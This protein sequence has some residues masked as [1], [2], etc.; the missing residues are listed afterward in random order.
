M[1]T[2]GKSTKHSLGS[3]L[4]LSWRH[5][6]TV[7]PAYWAVEQFEHPCWAPHRQQVIDTV[8]AAVL[9]Q[10][11]ELHFG[12]ARGKL[13]GDPA[14]RPFH[15]LIGAHVGIKNDEHRSPLPCDSAQIGNRTLHIDAFAFRPIGFPNLA[16]PIPNAANGHRDESRPIGFVAREPS[17]R[18]SL[19][20]ALN[21]GEWNRHILKL[22]ERYP[23]R[24]VDS[25]AAFRRP[26]VL[27][28]RLWL[29]VLPP[30]ILGV[31]APHSVVERPRLTR[32]VVRDKNA[33]TIAGVLLAENFP[34]LDR[35]DSAKLC[36]SGVRRGLAP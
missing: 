26:Q 20:L 6:I 35:V 32:P 13:S 12:T 23:R 21:N 10:V 4:E 29:A 28:V 16:A 22:F 1:F 25:I 17:E 19:F 30:G 33:G 27:S 5:D 36:F 2:F 34:A 7:H 18:Q 15:A 31:V 8:Y 9:R 14:A 11:D 24:D 3:R